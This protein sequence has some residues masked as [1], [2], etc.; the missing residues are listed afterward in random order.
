MLY[1]KIVDD[2]V[3]EWPLNTDDIKKAH[4]N[5]AFGP[6]P[7]E[8]EMEELGYTPIPTLD[9]EEVPKSD[10]DNEVNLGDL[11]KDADGNWIRTYIVTPVTDEARKMQRLDRQWASMRKHRDNLFSET[12][13]RVLRN[14]R[15]VTLG[16]TPSE[17][18]EILEQYR[19][20][21]A[22]ITDQE[23]PFNIAWPEKV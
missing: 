5:I 18:I 22:N 6:D 15:E 1:A 14:L 4:P 8:W 20:D 9:T 2:E 17:D 12:D 11:E 13:W 23:D 10:K 7:S 3:I 21:L 19:Q 16:L